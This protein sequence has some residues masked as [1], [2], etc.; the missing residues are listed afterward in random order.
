[1]IGKGAGIDLGPALYILSRRFD[2]LEKSGID[3]PAAS[4]ATEFGRDLEYYSGLV[5][6][7]EAGG[8][9]ASPIAGGGRY[10]GLLRS[11]GAPVEVPAVG[12]AIHTERL[13][14]AVRGLA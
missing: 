9:G 3:V 7:I 11:V 14:A 8:D 6:Q 2:L 12:S 13:L 1:M 4:F 10:D 5:F